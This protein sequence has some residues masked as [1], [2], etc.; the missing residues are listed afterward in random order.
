MM[1]SRLQLSKSLLSESGVIFVSIDDNEQAYLKVLMD[2]IFGEENFISILYWIRNPGGQSDNKFIAKTYE[3]I[4]Y[5]AKSK[6]HFKEFSN[7]L[8]REVEILDFKFNTKRN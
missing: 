1:K 6:E 4:L 5:Y 7:V 3:H 2:D 8:E